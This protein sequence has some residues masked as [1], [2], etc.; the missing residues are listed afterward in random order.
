MREEACLLAF[1]ACFLPARAQRARGRLLGGSDLPAR[2]L[3]TAAGEVALLAVELRR[4]SVC[5]RLRQRSQAHRQQHRMNAAVGVAR[6]LEG[7]LGIPPAQPRP[8]GGPQLVAPRLA[9]P[10]AERAIDLVEPVISAPVGKLGADGHRHL[11]DGRPAGDVL[12]A[13]VG[14]ERQ[15][16]DQ[17]R[18]GEPDH[19]SGKGTAPFFMVGWH[20]EGYRLS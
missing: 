13:G 10:G 5:L 8:L 4:K 6:G 20:D 1:L 18:G 14:R 9:D 16:N 15:Q 7:A 19:R 11:V 3:L 17:R 2:R 12:R